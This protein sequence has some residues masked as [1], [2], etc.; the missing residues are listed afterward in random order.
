M[1]LNFL[2]QPENLILLKAIAK[3]FLVSSLGYVAIKFHIFSAG[4]LDRLSKFVIFVSLP[5][6][7]IATLAKELRYDLLREMGFCVFA[8]LLLNGLGL[9]GALVM[10]RLFMMHSH[11]GRRLFL[12]L[13]SI[14][15]SGYLPI[16]LVIA[17]LPESQRAVGLLFVFVYI[18][19][20]GFLFWSLGVWLISRQAG[21]Q[22]FT[23]ILRNIVNPPMIALIAGLFFLIPSVRLGFASIPLLPKGLLA[24]GNTT[25]PLVL[26][27]LGGSFAKPL[28]GFKSGRLLINMAAAIKLIIIPATVLLVTAFLDIDKVFLFVLL[29]QAAMPAAMN[30]IVVAQEYDGDVPLVSQALF[31]QYLLALV[32]VPFFL[33]L[34]NGIYS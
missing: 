8:A 19:V 10:R 23:G 28:P 31:V 20:M 22:G 21:S 18:M 29:L 1:E 16:P 15:N 33:L 34:F 11:P 9:G 4:I 7:V 6:L 25:I 24:I 13:A 27:I 5:C 30:H 17:V 12:S 3:L 32:T 26:V 2:H 14:Q